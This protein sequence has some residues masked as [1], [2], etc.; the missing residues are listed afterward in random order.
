MLFKYFKLKYIRQNTF[1]YLQGI[2]SR[3]YLW[4][5]LTFC[6]GT[7]STVVT[8]RSMWS[9]VCY[10]FSSIFLL[11][12]LVYF[13][14]LVCFVHFKLIPTKPNS[15]SCLS[16]LPTDLAYFYFRQPFDQKCLK[17]FCPVIVRLNRIF[18]WDKICIYIYICIWNINDKST[19]INQTNK[20]WA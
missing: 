16:I 18:R 17:P 11:V 5:N 3:D 8:F 9:G 20:V 13:V 1:K 14:H 12:L 7:T 2:W 4:G 10:F 15:P 19:S 6:G